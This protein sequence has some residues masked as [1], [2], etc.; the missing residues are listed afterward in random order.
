M[1]E[2]D[3]SDDLDNLFEMG[4]SSGGARTKIL[5]NFDGEEWLI[6]FPVSGDRKEVGKLKFE[7]SQCAKACGTEM[8]ETKLFPSKRC[9]VFL[10]SKDSTGSKILMEVVERFT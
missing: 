4:G 1:L 3:Y 5:T 10:E 6:K 2:T 9:D 8:T 7:Y